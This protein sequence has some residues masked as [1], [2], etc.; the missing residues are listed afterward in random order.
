MNTPNKTQITGIII[1]TLSIFTY[2]G[3]LNLVHGI[4]PLSF[5]GMKL[6]ITIKDTS[7]NQPIQGAE[8]TITGIDWQDTGVHVPLNV[9]LKPTDSRGKCGTSISTWGTAHLSIQADGYETKTGVLTAESTETVSKTFKLTPKT[10]PQPDPPEEPEEPPTQE[11]PE[12]NTTNTE[13]PNT[14]PIDLSPNI[15]TTLRH[16][17]LYTGLVG[18]GLITLSK[19]S[20]EQR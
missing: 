17:S 12:E 14:P 5:T 18:I 19:T 7:N 3:G 15:S 1:L 4:Y 8:V 9:K 2:L 11:P 6:S 20:E 10:I 13:E 16:Y